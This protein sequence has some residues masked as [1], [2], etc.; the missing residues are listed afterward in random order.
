[1]ICPDCGSLHEPSPDVPEPGGMY[2][3]QC[4]CGNRII[5]RLEYYSESEYYQVVIEIREAV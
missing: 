4:P 2:Q 3:K 1:M 5:Y